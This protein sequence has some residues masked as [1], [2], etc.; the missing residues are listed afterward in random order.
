MKAPIESIRIKERIRKEISKI[1][2]LAA[3]IGKNGLLHPVTVMET[4]GGGL[5]LLAGLRRVKAAQSLG[6]MEIDV[7]IVSP[8]DAEAELQI[9]I[10]ENEQREQFTYSEQMDYARLF[11]EIESAKAKERMLSGKK[12]SDP[13]DGRPEG[14]YTREIVGAKIGMSGRQYSRAK[15]VADNAPPEVIDRL[16]KGGC[17]VN[18]AYKELRAKEPPKVVFASE[19]RDIGN[20]ARRI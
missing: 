16:D 11:E 3:D 5:Q 17:S 7:I 13:L 14:T 8:A 10:S 9:I 2:E 19:S 1:P 4:D 20:A 18:K 6:W 12:N 15:Y